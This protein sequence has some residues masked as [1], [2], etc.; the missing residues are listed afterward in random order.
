MTRGEGGDILA[1]ARYGRQEM[2]R[3]PN[4][5]SRKIE[6]ESLKTYESPTGEAEELGTL[7]SN[8]NVEQH[9]RCASGMTTGK[10]ALWLLPAILVRS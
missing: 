2:V 6:S 9:T 4:T 8:E 3:T 5:S 10:I 7:C 1:S